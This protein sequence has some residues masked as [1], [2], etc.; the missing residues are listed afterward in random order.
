[1][2]T[3]IVHAGLHRTGTTTLQ[4]FLAKH[5]D[6]L[7]EQGVHYPP[8]MH[9]EWA[10]HHRLA[11]RLSSGRAFDGP[12]DLFTA[13]REVFSEMIGAR[14]MALEAFAPGMATDLPVTLLSS[15][16]FGAFDAAEL[17]DLQ[18]FV[19]PIDR[20][21]LYVRNGVDF[22]HSCW[23]AKVRWGHQGSF[24]AF[25]RATVEFEPMTPVRG[26]L[27]FAELL[28]DRFGADRIKI[29]SFDAALAH[30]RGLIGDFIQ[31]ELGLAELKG[32]ETNLWSHVSPPVVVTEVQRALNIRAGP[33]RPGVA[34]SSHVA[35]RAA[36]AGASG[37]GMLADFTRRLAPIMKTIAIGDL[38]PVGLASVGSLQFLEEPLATLLW[39]WRF[40]L[41]ET[42][43]W[44]ATKDLMRAFEGCESFAR[45]SMT[46]SG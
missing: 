12:N 45:L 5:R 28:I 11:C 19:G 14:K 20:F 40:P 9:G 31:G 32:L 46:T 10:G 37:G 27:R 6:W 41:D 4:D 23:A 43:P 16:I 1:M 30:P 25:L 8:D 39:G 2:T 7:A 29:R 13:E 17:A 24:D 22:I 21:V 38:R 26:P 36:L 34:P 33:A 3:T 15:E 44:C 18:S 42:A 35:L